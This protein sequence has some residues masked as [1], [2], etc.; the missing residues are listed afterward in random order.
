MSNGSLESHLFKKDNINVLDWKTRYNISVGTAR[1]LTYLHEKCRDCIIHCDIK[2]ENILLDAEYNPKVADFGLAKLV[3][4]E[5]SRGFDNNE[6]N[7]RLSCT[8]M[9]IRL[10]GNCDVEE[11]IRACK[12][13]A[14]CIQDDEK[15]RPS[16]G[17]AGAVHKLGFN[18][19]DLQ[20]QP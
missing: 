4:R 14:W 18:G 10:E 15:D 12:V 5:I 8:R 20:G 17:Q 11:V 1:G 6:R 16:M 3:G 19:P 9:D 13:A 2:P 7:T